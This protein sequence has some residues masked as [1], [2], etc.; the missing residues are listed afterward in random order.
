MARPTSEPH[1]RPAY[2]HNVFDL[3]S[4]VHSSV[5]SAV[6]QTNRELQK[7]RVR[8]VWSLYVRRSLNSAV[9][10][11]GVLTPRLTVAQ[12]Q[13][14]YDAFTPISRL[15]RPSF[16]DISP[17]PDTSEAAE[18]FVGSALVGVSRSMPSPQ[19]RIHK[20]WVQIPLN[21]EHVPESL[22]TALAEVSRKTSPEP[23]ESTDFQVEHPDF[24]TV[25][26]NPRSSLHEIRKA[27]KLV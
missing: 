14:F 26:L 3:L 21:H 1:P 5:A 25:L 9:F 23:Y 13:R 16:S 15:V 19:G 4:Q 20:L 8:T 17:A 10:E 11:I 2:E 7:Q 12:E 22:K 18:G 27:L 6:T 24:F